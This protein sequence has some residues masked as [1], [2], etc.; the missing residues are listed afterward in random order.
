DR[1]EIL[2]ILAYDEDADIAERAQNALL[3]QPLDSFLKALD[4]ADSDPALF[5]YSAENLGAKP[6]I[7]DALAKNVGCPASLLTRVVPHMTSS[8]IQGLLDNLEQFCED[9]ALIEA[10]LRSTAPNAEQRALLDELTKGVLT[11]AE[12]ENA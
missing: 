4:R 10:V 12:I 11:S 6:A 2:S 7:A 1:A 3:S 5:R 8:G 9:H